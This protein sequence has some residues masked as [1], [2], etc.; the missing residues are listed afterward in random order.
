[1]VLKNPGRLESQCA[2]R[3]YERRNH[4]KVGLKKSNILCHFFLDIQHRVFYK[5]PQKRLRSTSTL[6]QQIHDEMG[7][8]KAPEKASGKRGFN[9]REAP[10]FFSVMGR[11]VG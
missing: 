3:V 9:L 10:G 2:T 1:L 8:L 7:C 4:P 11:P 6:K 5:G